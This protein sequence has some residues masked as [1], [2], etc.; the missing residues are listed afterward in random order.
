MPQ[1]SSP[2]FLSAPGA[3]NI[4]IFISLP[5]F[6]EDTF[7]KQAAA[8]LAAVL[9]FHFIRLQNARIINVIL[10]KKC[11]NGPAV[12]FYRCQKAP[13]DKFAYNSILVHPHL[14][15]SDCSSQMMTNV[16]STLINCLR[17]L[18]SFVQPADTSNSV[19]MSIQNNT[20][21]DDN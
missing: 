8:S 21:N 10:S 19:L 11:K 7:S 2:V 12:V 9:L 20:Y 1:F 18:Y 13:F 16:M 3:P 5:P 14:S 4:I 15:P 17:S 6:P